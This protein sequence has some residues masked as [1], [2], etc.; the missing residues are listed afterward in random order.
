MDKRQESWIEITSTRIDL[1]LDTYSNQEFHDNS[2]A[3]RAILLTDEK[4]NQQTKR[5]T[6]SPWRQNLI[7]T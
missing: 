2:S 6:Q 3:F 1:C 7:A 5:D 4:T